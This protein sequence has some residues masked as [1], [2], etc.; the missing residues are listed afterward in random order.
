MRLGFLVQVGKYS[1][2]DIHLLS[3]DFQA[4]DG[5]TISSLHSLVHIHN[6]FVLHL[7]EYHI[8]LLQHS[9]LAAS[10]YDKERIV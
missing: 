6:N 2:T 7:H 3:L 9:L 5:L 4:G 8:Y 1:D 10:D